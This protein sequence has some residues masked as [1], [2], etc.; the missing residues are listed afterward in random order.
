[1]KPFV[2]THHTE[3]RMREPERVSKLVC[4]DPDERE[5]ARSVE[6]DPHGP[7]ELVSIHFAGPTLDAVDRP[8]DASHVDAVALA[9][10]NGDELEAARRI[11]GVSGA[12]GIGVFEIAAD[13]VDIN[14]ARRSAAEQQKRERDE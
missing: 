3:V 4:H 2:E 14:G 1:M 10:M 7:A 11:P 6:S 5:F 12:Q 8:V 9:S 13:E